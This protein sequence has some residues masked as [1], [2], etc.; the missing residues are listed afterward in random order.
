MIVYLV[1]NRL[2]GK[3]YVG[4]TKY[5]LEWRWKEHLSDARCGSKLAFH[6]A[7]RKWGVDAFE[8]SIIETLSESAS[9]VDLDVAERRW[10]KD[11]DTFGKNGY[12][13]T[14]GGR[15]GGGWVKGYVV[16]Q[17]TREKLSLSRRGKKNSL[18]QNVLITTGVRAYYAT[19]DGP[20]KD[21]PW[22]DETRLK[23]MVIRHPRKKPVFGYNEIGECVIAY[24]SI[25]DAVEATGLSYRTLTGNR[26]KYKL[27]YVDG[28]TYR[29]SKL[30]IAEL[31]EEGR[32]HGLARQFDE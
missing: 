7:I 2:N 18:E 10:V 9:L 25:D 32:P 15:V 6:C 20:N 30:T 14:P 11:L 12:N 13:M 21:K 26:K 5:T 23:N 3:G 1:R 8:L 27:K 28:I 17:S 24:L 4:V 29:R 19:H 22:S 31:K 16:K